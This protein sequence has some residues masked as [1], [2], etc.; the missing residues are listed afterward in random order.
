MYDKTLLRDKLEQINEA[1]A[2]IERRFSGIG[3]P[4]D[5]T[6]TELNQDK[7]DAIAMLLIAIGESFKKI[8]RETEG[9][10]LRKYPDI[11][12]KGVI[13]VRDVLAHDYFDLDAEEIYKIC[14]YD[15][16]NLRKTLARMLE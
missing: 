9:E 8:D 12:W 10:F 11:D 1:V 3:S 2:R 4:S 5:F 7:L 6:T 15:I 13:G 16:P 14:K